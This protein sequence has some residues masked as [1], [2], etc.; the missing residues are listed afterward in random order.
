M[1]L[2]EGPEPDAV[3]WEALLEQRKRLE[4]R[5]KELE[6]LCHQLRGYSI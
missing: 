4:R 2:P 6:E 3:E 5:L 1:I